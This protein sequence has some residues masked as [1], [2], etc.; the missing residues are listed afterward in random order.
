[1]A[2]MQGIG[3]HGGDE[4]DPRGIQGPGQE[5]DQLARGA[6]DPLQILDDEH[7]WRLAS[8]PADDAQ[9]LAVQA[10]LGQRRRR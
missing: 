3:P 6:V 7:E 4:N 2:R 5:A 8:Q 10:R 1:M 9:Q